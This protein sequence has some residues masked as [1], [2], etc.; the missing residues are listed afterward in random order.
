MRVKVTFGALI[1]DN[2]LAITAFESLFVCSLC[3]KRIETI[4]RECKS[5]PM[6]TLLIV[7]LDAASN[8][9]VVIAST[10]ILTFPSNVTSSFTVW[11]LYE[12]LHSHW[13]CFWAPLMS[14]NLATT[15]QCLQPPAA[16]RS[17]RNIDS[18]YI[19]YAEPMFLGVPNPM[20][21]EVN[22]SEWEVNE[23]PWMIGDC[24]IEFWQGVQFYLYII[25][26][27]GH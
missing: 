15:V 19:N 7:V 8:K 11:D 6:T 3:S 12:P 9:D 4:L 22:S 23:Y 17:D 26:R 1:S 18:N 10:A 5:I 20:E 21:F 2:L 16:F 24:C 13:E 27:Q 14:E 25:D